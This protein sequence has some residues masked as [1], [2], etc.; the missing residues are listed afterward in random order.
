MIPYIKENEEMLEML[1]RAIKSVYAS[2]F[3]KSSKAYMEATKNV[4]DEEKMAIIL[5]E[6]TGSQYGDRFYPTNSAEARTV[7]F[8]PIEP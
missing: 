7:N 3:F 6:V 1:Y 8:Y 4:I 2:V 5:Q